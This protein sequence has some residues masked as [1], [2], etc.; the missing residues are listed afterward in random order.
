MGN[1]F[2]NH[3]VEPQE[4]I[5]DGFLLVRRIKKIA[6]L[7]VAHLHAFEKNNIDYKIYRTLCGR[8]QKSC[9]STAS[10]LYHVSVPVCRYDQVLEIVYQV[11]KKMSKFILGR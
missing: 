11:D 1:F 7:R 4:S 2:V 6:R 8:R 10:K 9:G 5:K 3:I